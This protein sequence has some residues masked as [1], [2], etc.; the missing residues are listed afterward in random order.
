MHLAA[1]DRVVHELLPALE[2]LQT[3]LAAKAEQFADVTP[4]AVT[5]RHNAPKPNHGQA[6]SW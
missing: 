3:S 6:A 4:D 5:T 1:L 2:Q